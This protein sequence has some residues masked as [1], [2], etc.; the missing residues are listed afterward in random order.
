MHLF[1]RFESS[2]F[3]PDRRVAAVA[4]TA[5]IAGGAFAA[6][7]LVAVAG[8]VYG[9]AAAIAL[10]AGVL[11]LRDVRWGFLAIFAVIAFIPFATLPFKIGF[12]PTFLNLA[13]LVVYFVWIMR[14]ATRRD[15]E[16][17]RQPP[18]GLR[19]CSSCSWPFLRLRRGCGSAARR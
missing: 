4:L 17:R 19:S 5:L 16:L 14:I 9:A 12:T 10:V 7:M 1:H 6:A 3:S 2:L 15:R 18:S 13:L 8:P 11:M